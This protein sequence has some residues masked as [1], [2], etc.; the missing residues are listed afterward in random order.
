M[1][2]NISQ[3]NGN[4]ASFGDWFAKTN[5]IANAISTS[6]LSIGLN[7]AGDVILPGNLQANAVFATQISG[8]EANT[9]GDLIITTN[10]TM[11]ATSTFS[12]TVFQ[13]AN[14]ALGLVANL[15]ILGSNTTH[16]ILAANTTSNKLRFTAIPKFEVTPPTA[17]NGSIVAY[18]SNDGEYVNTDSLIITVSNGNVSTKNDL[19]V[20][21]NLS[22]TGNTAITGN[23]S[24]TGR[25]T[26]ANTSTLAGLVSANNLNVT[27]NNVAVSSQMTV[28]NNFFVTGNTT[29]TRAL[30]VANNVNVDGAIFATGDITGLSD[31]RVK[32][33]IKQIQNALDRV[34]SI[35]GYTFY[36]NGSKKRKTG[37]IA[38]EVQEVL[39]EAVITENE[40]LTVAYGNMVGLLVEAIK[41]LDEK[42]QQIGATDGTET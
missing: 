12:N 3:L 26:V 42:I 8:G 37:V 7:P 34:K 36:I 15:N 25:L 27:T 5:Q 31:K 29:L 10:T 17:A 38:Q 39:P 4:T 6:A 13:G 19:T 22:V 16:F 14:N 30:A 9:P 33:E 21:Q 23:T 28:S 24:I 35:T 18:N 2:I 11:Q 32:T 40:Y 41:E 1:A 20:S